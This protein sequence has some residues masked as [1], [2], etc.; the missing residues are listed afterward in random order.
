[1]NTSIFALESIP[2]VVQLRLL[3]PTV[4]SYIPGHIG[5]DDLLRTSNIL[6]NTQEVFVPI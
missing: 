1:M 3:P 5:G 6:P 2:N 4:H